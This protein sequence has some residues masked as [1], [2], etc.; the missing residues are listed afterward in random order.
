MIKSSRATLVRGTLF[1]GILA[2]ALP[3]MATLRVALLDFT[4]D[5]NSWPATQAASDFTAVL[6]VQLSGL[7]G[8]EWVERAQLKLAARELQMSELGLMAGSEAVRRGKWVHADWLLLGRFG[9]NDD[10][11]R[12]VRLELLDLN[13]AELLGEKTI[14]LGPD[15]A[16]SATVDKLAPVAQA[17]KAI[18][19]EG[20]HWLQR[21]TNQ[22]TVAPIFFSEV[23]SRFQGWEGSLRPLER[24]FHEFLGEWAAQNSSARLLRF[25]K[26]YQSLDEAVLSSSGRTVANPWQ[27]LANLYV[28]GSCEVTNVR[29]TNGKSAGKTVRITINAWDGQGAPARFEERLSLQPREEIPLPKTIAALDGLLK[30]AVRPART[31]NGKPDSPEV[32]QRIARS[33]LKDFESLTPEHGRTVGLTHSDDERERFMDLVRMLEA[34]C[35]FDPDNPAA[36]ARRIS[37]RWGWWM[38]FGDVSSE[39]WSKWRRSEEWGK[40]ADRFGI[41]PVIP[42]PFPHYRGIA[43]AYEDS[44]RDVARMMGISNKEQ[45]YG[46]PT[47]VPEAVEE[48][49]TA[50]IDAETRKRKAMAAAEYAK[51]AEQKKTLRATNSPTARPNR[52]QNA[53]PSPAWSPA[54]NRIEPSATNASRPFDWQRSVPPLFAVKRPSLLPPE[55]KP[56][57]E[58][59]AFPERAAVTVVNQ[60]LVR[61]DQL[62]LVAE[63]EKSEGA[64]V[65]QPDI[66][67]EV[68]AEASRVWT[69]SLAAPKPRLF[70][71][72]GIPRFV[73]SM[74]NQGDMLW[75]A[76][77]GIAR[78]QPESGRVQSFGAREGFV[79][80]NVTSVSGS[81]A[82]DVYA[83]GDSC[84]LLRLPANGTQWEEIST[85]TAGARGWGSGDP[86]RIDA[87][88]D[89]LLLV[90]G[91]LA[92][93]DPAINGWTNFGRIKGSTH[94]VA[95]EA[96]GFWIAS[97]QG[98]AQLTGNPARLRSWQVDAYPSWHAPQWLTT[99]SVARMGMNT[100]MATGLDSRPSEA[101]TAEANLQRGFREFAKARRAAYDRRRAAGRTTDPQELSTRLTTG[102]SA[103]AHDGDFLWLGFDYP[104]TVMLYH[105]PSDS[106]VGYVKLTNSVQCLAVSPGHLWIGFGY[107]ETKLARMEKRELLATPQSRWVANRVGAREFS[108]LLAQQPLRQQA[109]HAFFA[110]DYPRTLAI[111]DRENVN[112]PDVETMFL[113]AYCYDPMGLNQP[114][115]CRRQ[116]EAIIERFAGYPWERVARAALEESESPLDSAERRQKL[117][118]KVIND[119]LQMLLKRCDR[120]GDQ[121]LNP[122]EFTS[123]WR[124]LPAYFRLGP[125]ARLQ[126]GRYDANK[127]SFVDAI[128][129]RALAA[130]LRKEQ[131]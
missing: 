56:R 36:H 103:L 94:A 87:H 104:G 100:A 76:G 79:L 2:L 124:E 84:Q 43:G 27:A 71:P 106:F 30:K 5:D 9:F 95:V 102:V 52:P 28:W 24:R 31:G 62:W 8:V 70:Q 66:A 4:A 78:V 131:E 38:D 83:V 109:L 111:L 122:A 51:L 96:S 118:E 77:S 3:A 98:L 29:S 39:F 12:I 128:E 80:G 35:F 49:W 123:L 68:S 117:L 63:D 48:R 22:I 73:A 45:S 46:F 6:Q 115:E 37:T 54:S 125:Q 15:Q 107:Q 113:R 75:L 32:R 17:A 93:L 74:A 119:R 114:A 110:G 23:T 92:V 72:D 16:I 21:A 99:P 127:D 116:F 34:A 126:R 10:G 90:A 97:D 112:P 85:R 121:K 67:T 129:L 55:F 33:L 130:D 53:T 14:A 44:S 13:H 19:T 18:L 42:L 20:E 50:E 40:Y 41:A 25:P 89:Q 105:K 26:A 88:R 65:P 57:I 61:G 108:E 64:N 47:G 69:A 58:P 1:W 60:L 91:A 59:I 11:R 120:D 82:S 7:S 81:E 101:E 86:L